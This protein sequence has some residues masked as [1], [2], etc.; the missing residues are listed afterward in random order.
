[1]A[2]QI[3]KGLAADQYWGNRAALWIILFILLDDINAVCINNN[4]NIMQNVVQIIWHPSAY[5]FHRK[6][7]V[8]I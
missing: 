2:F 4:T 5:Y 7:V 1:M 8:V 6:S 3:V